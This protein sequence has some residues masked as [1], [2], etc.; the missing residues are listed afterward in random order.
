M[1][2]IKWKLSRHIRGGGPSQC[3]Q[4][5]H[6]GEVGSKIAVK[7]VT[8]YLNGTLQY[9]NN[10]FSVENHFLLCLRVYQLIVNVHKTQNAY[11]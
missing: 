6:G 2:S 10:I 9:I 7:S 8:Y 1:F 5:T 3:H 4:M 11:I